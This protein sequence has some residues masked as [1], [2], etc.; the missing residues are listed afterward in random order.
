MLKYA[1]FVESQLLFV[2]CLEKGKCV[3]LTFSLPGGI[4][5]IVRAEGVS[6]MLIQEMREQNVV[7]YI[8]LFD[9]TRTSGELELAVKMLVVPCECEDPGVFA[10]VIESIINQIVVGEQVLLS[11]TPVY[12]ASVLLLAMKIANL[13]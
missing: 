9:S 1:E 4:E 11:I 2:K 6:R 13:V 5:R 12:G 10:P 8:D 3:E 7:E